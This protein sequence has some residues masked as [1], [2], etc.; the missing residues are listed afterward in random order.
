[1]K[2]VIFVFGL[3]VGLASCTRTTDVVV[4]KTDSTQSV[5]KVDTAK[6]TVTTTTVVVDSTNKSK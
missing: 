2:K 4:S 6:K 1:M 5:V 3:I